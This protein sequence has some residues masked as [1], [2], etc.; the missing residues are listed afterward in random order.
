MRQIGWIVGIVITALFPLIAFV[1]ASEAA[2]AEACAEYPTAASIG[3]DCE[4]GPDAGGVPTTPGGENAENSD[5]S[6]SSGPSQPRGEV[7]EP[8]E[9]QNPTDAPGQWEKATAKGAQ[10]LAVEIAELIAD[11]DGAGR[12]GFGLGADQLS[13]YAIM[14]ALGWLLAFAALVVSLGK[15][16]KAGAM[17][18][19]EMIGYV[20]IR[21]LIFGPVTAVLPLVLNMIG[22]VATGLASGFFEVAGERVTDSMWWFAG[23]LGGLGGAAVIIPGGSVISLIVLLML[24]GCLLAVL[25]ELLIAKY[26]VFI[27]ALVLPVL[28]AV[29]INPAWRG[30][31][32]KVSGVLLGAYLA[33]A[34]LFFVWAATWSLVS[35]PDAGDRGVFERILLFLLGLVVSISAPMAIGMI[36]S[37]VVP[38]LTGGESGDYRGAV[39]G[40]LASAG[41]KASGAGHRL[42]GVGASRGAR[43]NNAS[44]IHHGG[45]DGPG[46]G[47]FGAAR[48]ANLPGAG[49][50][51]G[52][53]KAGGAVT[54]AAGAGAAKGAAGGPIGVAAAAAVALGKRG[55]QKVDGAREK[56][57][58]TTAART[59]QPT[60][61][62]QAAAPKR[63]SSGE[64]S[65]S[66]RGQTE[67]SS[68]RSGGVAAPESAGTPRGS[69]GTA[70]GSSPRATGTAT[71]SSSSGSRP[72]PAPA[73]T[74][75]A[76]SSPASGGG[77]S[78]ASFTPPPPRS[79]RGGD[80]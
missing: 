8:F 65:S 14:W 55:F 40:A 32:K 38:A 20:A 48:A 69:T 31:V 57:A 35:G 72:K 21:M 75:S 51:A 23:T 28:L 39:T 74:G 50:G 62:D 16:A 45:K 47:Q 43:A 7:A 36:L 25:L 6:A 29:S 58:A 53:A 61:S 22:D 77:G 71:S 12:D 10:D 54:G 60:A 11:E 15:I 73:S 70:N 4:S 64:E 42:R 13:L 76:K 46:A 78:R 1:S 30:G 5:E 19:R 9:G 17:G 80:V 59:E 52:V 67:G 26:I 41:A 18:S 44:A 34:A 33:P 56:V 66:A 27:L 24:I 2:G 37:H 63:A 68:T 79:T 3:A 49:G